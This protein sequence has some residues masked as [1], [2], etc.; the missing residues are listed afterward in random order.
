M[1]RYGWLASPP[2]PQA[3]RNLRPSSKCGSE[4]QRWKPVLQ[5]RVS[6][7]RSGPGP[8]HFAKIVF[9]DQDHPHIYVPPAELRR[10]SGDDR[11]F[12]VSAI[13]DEVTIGGGWIARMAVKLAGGPAALVK[14]AAQKSAEA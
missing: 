3:V 14:L 4:P 11:S 7:S 2:F 12:A 8:E 9:R 13:C 1:N 10:R 6:H 5:V